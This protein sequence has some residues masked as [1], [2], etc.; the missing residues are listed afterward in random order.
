[1]SDPKRRESLERKL[2]TGELTLEDPEVRRLLQEDPALAEAVRD[3]L[4]AEASLASLALARDRDLEAAEREPEVATDA[5]RAR[6]HEWSRSRSRPRR[7]PFGAWLVAAAALVLAGWFLWP[8]GGAPLD[9]GPGITLGT[10][11]LRL[12]EGSGGPLLVWDRELG[13]GETFRVRLFDTEDA[14]TPFLEREADSSRLELESAELGGRESFFAQVSVQG[15]VPLAA[16]DRV[17]VSL[18]R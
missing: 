11:E 12:E 4:E 15:E 6:V 5:I 18:P 8:S 17:P 9:P 10:W 7:T 2:L 3:L 14:S 13:P 16:S 1:M